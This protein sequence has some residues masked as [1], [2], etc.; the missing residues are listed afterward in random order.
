[1][2]VLKLCKRKK[3]KTFLRTYTLSLFLREGFPGGSVVKNPPA[4]QES[5][6]RLLN[7]ED[8]LEENVATHSSTLAWRIPGPEEPGGL[9]SMGSQRVGHDWATEQLQKF[10]R[11]VST[12]VEEL[13]CCVSSLF[14][15][16]DKSIFLRFRQTLV[17]FGLNGQGAKILATVRTQYSLFR[18]VRLIQLYTVNACLET[19]I[20]VQPLLWKQELTAPRS[21][22][23]VSQC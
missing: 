12:V 9:Q 23:L 6:V 13:A 18:M 4:M 15:K 19:V 8:P 20:D 14:S 10:L 21:M 16:R 1:M 7:W 3:W 17:L 5:W 11:E 22:L 2:A